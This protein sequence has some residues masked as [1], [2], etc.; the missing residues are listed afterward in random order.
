MIISKYPQSFYSITGKEPTIY[1]H[2]KTRTVT[3]SELFEIYDTQVKAPGL[4]DSL[5]VAI[6]AAGVASG[7][8]AAVCGYVGLATAILAYAGNDYYYEARSAFKKAVKYAIANN[9]SIDIE[10][11]IWEVDTGTSHGMAYEMQTIFSI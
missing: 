9:C 10:S 5:S 7:L 3:P 4:P 1:Q 8:L 6:S 2:L 11:I